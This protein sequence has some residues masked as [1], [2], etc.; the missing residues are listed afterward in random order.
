MSSCASWQA[1]LALKFAPKQVCMSYMWFVLKYPTYTLIGSD[2]EF[3]S[4]THFNNSKLVHSQI[5]PKIDTLVKS[6]LAHPLRF[7]HNLGGLLPWPLCLA[8]STKISK[9]TEPNF[10]KPIST[11]GCMFIL[12]MWNVSQLTPTTCWITQLLWNFANMTS[13][14]LNSSLLQCFLH[15]QFEAGIVWIFQIDI[16]AYPDFTF[17]CGCSNVLH[18][19]SGFG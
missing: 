5:E 11:H 18:H 3:R 12:N 6:T 9:P 15:N 7:Q 8:A 10:T 4:S 1:D 17:D 19:I 13:S 16:K 2:I 14:I